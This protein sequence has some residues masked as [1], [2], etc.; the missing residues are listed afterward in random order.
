MTAGPLGNSISP[1]A[2]PN[3]S[4]TTD[5][6]EHNQP[7]PMADAVAAHQEKVM[8]LLQQH[9]IVCQYD[10]KQSCFSLHGNVDA[11]AY[12]IAM[13]KVLP[14]KKRYNHDWTAW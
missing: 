13:F 9:G 6:D 11:D 5:V 12:K 7:S 3:S 2:V 14:C 4:L 10:E 8:Q 1:A